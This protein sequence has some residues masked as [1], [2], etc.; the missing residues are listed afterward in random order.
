MLSVTFVCVA[1]AAAS[2]ASSFI[3]STRSLSNVNTLCRSSVRCSRFDGRI[4]SLVV[5]AGAQSPAV[6]SGGTST[7]SIIRSRCCTGSD[8]A[9]V[10]RMVVTPT[11][12]FGL[13]DSLACVISGSYKKT[14][15]INLM[16]NL[17]ET[18]H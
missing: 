9:D 18:P 17:Q 3:V 4:S 1:A 10:G 2:F 15:I 12:L 14:T 8:A 16:L 5:A 13:V 11:S 6:F 7:V